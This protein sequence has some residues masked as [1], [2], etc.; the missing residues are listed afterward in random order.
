MGT[1]RKKLSEAIGNLEPEVP[2]LRRGEGVRLSVEETPSPQEAV[3][4]R[5]ALKDDVPV[6]IKPGYTL[7]KD[8]IRV[9]KQIALETE[10]KVYQVMEEALEEY[11]EHYKQ[12]KSQEK[13]ESAKGDNRES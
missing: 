7:R 2:E 6:R 8:L 5:G 3:S 9:C 11:I 1:S 12:A 13:Q 4:T 10:K